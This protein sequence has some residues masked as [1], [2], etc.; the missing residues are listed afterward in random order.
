MSNLD[1]YIDM[2]CPKEEGSNMNRDLYQCCAYT[3]MYSR[4]AVRLYFWDDYDME[5]EDKFKLFNRYNEGDYT[6]IRFS[7]SERVDLG[8]TFKD[9]FLNK[10]GIK[11]IQEYYKKNEDS[12]S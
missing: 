9:D 10:N 3:W 4:S 5:N 8:P 12:V 11:K 2:I 6:D 1:V 7:F